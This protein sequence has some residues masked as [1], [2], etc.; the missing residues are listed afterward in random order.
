[1]VTI[2]IVS[3]GHGILVTKLL[4]QLRNLPCVSQIILTINIPEQLVFSSDDLIELIVN[5]T[6]VGFGEN[7]N[8]AFK[9]CRYPFFCVM[10]PDIELIEDPFPS[11]LESMK[12][13]NVS[14]IAP[15]ILS[16]SGAIEDSAREFPTLISLFK[17]LI[18]SSEG[19]WPLNNTDFINYPDWVAGMFMLFNSDVFEDILGFDSNFFMYYEDVDICKR[20]TRKKNKIGICTE[21]KVIHDARRSS[22]KN[23]RFFL[24]HLHSLF[25]YLFL[26]KS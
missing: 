25:R 1:M 16:P 18:C 4:A 24:W 26:V 20:L 12:L 7:H 15:T 10:N 8:N 13:Y 21:T 11:L 23:F 17:K 19:R 6:P 2:S 9:I 3:H 5:E 22:R 14:L